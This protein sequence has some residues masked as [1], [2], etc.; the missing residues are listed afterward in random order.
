MDSLRN[1]GNGFFV[2]MQ[3]NAKMFVHR[4]LL[5]IITICNNK[6]NIGWKDTYIINFRK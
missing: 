2:W 1:Q 5:K 4:L 6:K 3:F